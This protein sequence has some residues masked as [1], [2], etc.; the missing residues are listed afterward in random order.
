ME[1]LKKCLET[2]DFGKQNRP[3]SIPLEKGH[4]TVTQTHGHHDYLIKSAQ[5]ADSMKT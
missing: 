1:K 3:P 2:I 4:S 5:W